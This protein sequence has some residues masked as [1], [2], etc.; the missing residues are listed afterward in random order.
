MPSKRVQSISLARST[1]IERAQPA[2]WATSTSRTELEELGEP[3]TIIASTVGDAL[4]CFLP[5]GGGVADVFLV[6]PDHRR[7]APLQHRDDGAGVVD[8]ERRLCDEGEARRIARHKQLGI[9]NGFD[10][11]DGALGQLPHGAPPLRGG[12]DGRSRRSRGPRQSAVAPRHAPWRPA[13]RWH[14]GRTSAAPPHRPVLPW[15]RHGLKTPP[16]RRSRPG[17][18]R[19]P[20]RTP[21]PSPSARR[22]RIYYGRWRAAHRPAR[23][24]SPAPARRSGSRGR[25]RHK[26]RAART[27]RC[28]VA[29]LFPL[30]RKCFLGRG[31]S[32]A[33]AVERS[34]AQYALPLIFGTR[35]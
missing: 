29:A 7:K 17:S 19:A 4:H 5:V 22:R 18:R 35:R 6:R 1:S 12:R 23:R 3:T 34:A 33:V 27:A 15:A 16:A 10:Q 2:R 8:A 25:R 28:Q 30:H 31:K 13:G 24:I 11:A 9:G 20:R 21:R 26:S 14:R 32:S